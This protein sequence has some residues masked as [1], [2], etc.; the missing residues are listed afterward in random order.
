[1]FVAF[2]NI[3]IPISLGLIVNNLSTFVNNIGDWSI[4]EFISTLQHPIFNLVTLYTLQGISTLINISTIAIIGEKLALKL[5]I[6][7]FESILNQDIA[8]FEKYQTGQIISRLTNDVQDF[9]SAF[10]LCISQGIRSVTQVCL[11][12]LFTI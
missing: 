6:E 10:K 11:Q 8:F 5:R 3:Q 4:S 9:K 2:L 7:L 1:L 12:S